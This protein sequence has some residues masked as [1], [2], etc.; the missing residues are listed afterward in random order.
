MLCMYVLFV[1]ICFVLYD[2]H[3]VYV[4]MCVSMSVCCICMYICDVG[5]VMYVLYVIYV[6]MS[7]I[8]V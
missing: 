1:G 6:R 7:V 4:C 2:G 8:Y 3:D 5:C